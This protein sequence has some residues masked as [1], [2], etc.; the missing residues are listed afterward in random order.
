M[1]SNLIAIV[2]KDLKLGV[3]DIIF[4]SAIFALVVVINLH[5]VYQKLNRSILYISIIGNWEV[6]VLLI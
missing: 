5:Q 6:S 3:Q 2:V 1:K 4:L